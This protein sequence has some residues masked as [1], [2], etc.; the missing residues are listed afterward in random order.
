[1]RSSMPVNSTGGAR[2]TSSKDDWFRILAVKTS[3]WSGKPAAFTLA[4]ATVIV[5][6]L[7]G[8]IFHYSDTWQLVI[9][10]G[11]TIITFLMVFLIQATQNRDAAAIQ[12]KLDEL[13]RALSSAHNEV[14]AAEE[15]Q[16]K[17]IESLKADIKDSCLELPNRTNVRP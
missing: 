2:R 3:Q 13:I 10:T 5:W 9:N 15:L 1:M 11:T 16:D 7:T 8:P 17:E 12:L 14:I 6:A 4:V